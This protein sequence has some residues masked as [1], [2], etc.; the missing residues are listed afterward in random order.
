MVDF[1]F[2]IVEEL[3]KINIEDVISNGKR[4]SSA[5]VIICCLVGI[6]INDNYY[7][8]ISKLFSLLCMMPDVAHKTCEDWKVLIGFI[9]ESFRTTASV[10]MYTFINRQIRL[11]NKPF[12]HPS[13]LFAIPVAH[14][15]RQV[16]EPFQKLQLDPR[17]IEWGDSFIDLATVKKKNYSD[18]GPQ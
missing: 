7:C 14:F 18:Y 10:A 5:I 16:S 11:L 2:N 12:S 1:L 4:M 8:Q 13:W 3:S 6:T 17:K 15:L 9:P